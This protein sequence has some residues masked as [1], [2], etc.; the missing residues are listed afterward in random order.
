LIPLE[1]TT[2]QWLNYLRAWMIIG[3]VDI[4]AQTLF[5]RV[6]SAKSERV[7]QNSFYLGSAGYLIFGMIPVIL[8]II[9]STTMPG[10]AASES[11]IPAMMVEHLHPVAVAVFVGALLAA[12]MSSADSALL[13]VS[14]LIAK[15]VLP[16]VKRDL[17][18]LF[19]GIR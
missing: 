5:Q 15:N 9:A 3:V 16:M 6:A 8:G 2:E 12:I 1:N 18:L 4:S 7:A 11:I 17:S 13:A 19:S 10:L 14:S